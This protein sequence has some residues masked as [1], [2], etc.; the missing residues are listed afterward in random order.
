MKDGGRA[1][2]LFNRGSDA[3]E[4]TANWTDIG[5]P[6]NVNASVRD[7]WEHKDLGKSS[8]KFSARVP[9]HGVVM[10]SIKP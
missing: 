7:L 2:V 5:Y 1:V 3:Q 6:A 10:V 4:V 8:G 9:S